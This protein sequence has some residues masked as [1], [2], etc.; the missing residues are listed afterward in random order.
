M[1]R[2]SSRPAASGAGTVLF[3]CEKYYLRF[4]RPI[5]ADLARAGFRPIWVS[6]DG[7][8]EWPHE[9]LD[10]RTA[11]QRLV[12]SDHVEESGDAAD[13]CRFERAVFADPELFRTNYAYTMNVVGTLE[14]ATRF[15]QA[16]SR[17]TLALVRRFKPKAVFVWNGRYL[18][19]SAVSRACRQVG[20][21]LLTSEIG[22]IPGTVFLDR[23]TLSASVVDLQGR[24]V[25]ERGPVDTDRA[26][27][28]LAAYTSAKAT[29]V[30]QRLV[31]PEVVRRELLGASGRFLLVYGCQVDWDTNIVIGARRFRSNAAAVTF[32]MEAL[33]PIEGAR[34]VVKT[35]PLDSVGANSHLRDLVGEHGQIVTDIHP[36]TLIEAADC[37]AIRNSTLGF[38]TLCYR[39]PLLLLEEAKY[40]H[41][42]LT[43]EASD[44]ASAASQLAAIAAGRRQ[45]PDPVRLKRLIV[46]LLD[47]YLVPTP[48]EYFFDPAKLSML[49]HFTHNDSL[50][51]L[52]GVL[53]GA[54]PAT[55]VADDDAATSIAACG[56][57][58]ERTSNRF[59]ARVARKV[60][61]WTQRR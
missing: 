50:A 8:D 16:W 41:P 55:P 11:V 28:F 39:K 40:R 13:R 52:R 49:T 43:L 22:W 2:W 3:V 44:A 57:L 25:D 59:I 56:L 15:D 20:Q 29:M 34:I 26:D 30:S 10:S 33:R 53:D 6:V 37:V 42:D 31:S 4:Y 46:H 21:L 58:H 54:T 24:D 51:Q 47:R 12:V 45:G 38:E 48:Y 32:L 7:P 60:T 5:A 1:S 36:H 18:P 19:Y 35:H 27:A 14:R 23:G 61:G 17:A 9:W